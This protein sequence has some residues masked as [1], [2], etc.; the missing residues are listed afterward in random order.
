LNDSNANILNNFS[1]IIKESN[2]VIIH[3][4][5]KGKD[6][7]NKVYI[8]ITEPT[9]VNAFTEYFHTLWRNIAPVNKDKQLVI[10]W[11]KAE[12]KSINNL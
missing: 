5:S 6:N 10:A 12:I 11:L 1:W 7:G 3:N 2:A 8:S 9:I 4:L